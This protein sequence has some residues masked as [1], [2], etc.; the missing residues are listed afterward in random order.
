MVVYW[1]LA[2]LIII[3]L[4]TM[5]RFDFF[6]IGVISFLLYT[7][8]CFWGDTYIPGIYYGAISDD[9]YLA[10]NSMLMVIFLSMI[11][12][13]LVTRIPDNK[14]GTDII[15]VRFQVS[16][17]LLTLLSIAAMM[18]TI[19]DLGFL[20]LVNSKRVISGQI[21]TVSY[22]FSLWSALVVFTYGKI[23][24]KNIILLVSL[25]PIFFNLFIGSRSF[26][27]T[28]FI[29]YFLLL[30]YNDRQFIVRNKK[31]IVFS[32]V[33]FLGIL[34]YK[35][36]YKVV[37][38]FD[39]GLIGSILTDS[40]TYTKIFKLEETQVVLSTLNYVLDI[41]YKLSYY[42][43]IARIVSVIPFAN[44]YITDVSIRF[45]SLVKNEIFDAHYG[46]ASNI[47][48]ETYS[49]GGY[50]GMYI[51]VCLWIV[52]LMQGNKMLN[53][54]TVL[55]KIFLIPAFVQVAFYIHRL[56]FVQIV[57]IY[58]QILLIFIIWIFLYMIA[59]IFIARKET[60]LEGVE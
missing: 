55:Q 11:I 4:A 21:N 35:E 49:M 37:K 8:P 58:K 16:M 50:L 28:V 56:D 38:T 32:F 25:I 23:T 53:K 17:N 54:G 39:L 12:Y 30:W 45:S 13:D 1:L 40:S 9:T 48:A 2:C 36:I 20:N 42:E 51:M 22:G 15:S 41:D 6:S 7:S 10:V 57:A 29:I 27:A 43:A 31:S 47:W 5:R 46:L 26:A 44:N 14:I 3:Y 34:V 60:A 24:K 18:Y 33:T 59:P 19:Y 52:L